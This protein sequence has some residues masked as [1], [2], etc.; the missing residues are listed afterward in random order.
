MTAG[1]IFLFLSAPSL[2][3]L[4][5]APAAQYR[6]SLPFTLLDVLE[7]GVGGGGLG[8]GEDTKTLRGTEEEEDG[9]LNL[10]ATGAG[11][12]G[13]GGAPWTPGFPCQPRTGARRGWRED[14]I[15]NGLEFLMPVYPV[16]QPVWQQDEHLCCDAPFA[17]V[18]KPATLLRLRA[19]GREIRRR[20]AQ[21][22]S[23]LGKG[24]GRGRLG[25][26]LEVGWGG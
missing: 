15:R 16:L 21:A 6:K 20:G 9:C 3:A 24:V 12:L 1:G 17:C 5:P 19:C 25:R 7:L 23:S 22:L 10:L 14:P 11:L 26:G 2:P 18:P 4:P 13:P 8:D